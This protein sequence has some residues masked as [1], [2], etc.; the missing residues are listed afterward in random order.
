MHLIEV[1]RIECRTNMLQCNHKLDDDTLPEAAL[2]TKNDSRYIPLRFCRHY[3]NPLH[4]KKFGS[5]EYAERLPMPHMIAVP[6]S[7]SDSD[8]DSD[9][10]SRDSYRPRNSSYDSF[11]PVEP[12]YYKQPRGEAHTSTSRDNYSRK[13]AASN[14]SSDSDHASSRDDPRSH[15]ASWNRNVWDSSKQGVSVSD[16][17]KRQPPRDR[18][19]AEFI[20]LENSGLWDRY[21]PPLAR[22]NLDSWSPAPPKTARMERSRSR[23]PSREYSLRDRD[24]DYDKADRHIIRTGDSSTKYIQL[25]KHD[26]NKIHSIKYKKGEKETLTQ[27]DIKKWVENCEDCI[28]AHRLPDFTNHIDKEMSRMFCLEVCSRTDRFGEPILSAKAKK[29]LRRDKN[30]IDSLVDF[31]SASDVARFRDIM[32]LAWKI[33]QPKDFY[34]NDGYKTAIDAFY[35]TKLHIDAIDETIHQRWIMEINRQIEIHELDN[36]SFSNRNKFT[37]EQWRDMWEAFIQSIERE[38]D[39]KDKNDKNP[40][41]YCKPE[42]RKITE[43]LKSFRRVDFPQAV[44]DITGMI[45]AYQDNI[46]KLSTR[47]CLDVKSLAP[48][49][50][51]EKPSE[52]SHSK[53]KKDKYKKN[54]NSKYSTKNENSK[55]SSSSKSARESV[56]M[57]IVESLVICYMASCRLH[58]VYTLY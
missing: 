21:E 3:S 36:F 13:R 4:Y 41:G 2:P 45:R 37:P 35:K 46:A 1:M 50:L 22:G 27:D 44:E 52:D 33:E 42:L 10:N 25:V 8:S 23:S 29:R 6:E 40:R 57:F 30:R 47:L 5:Y 24:L 14:E 53:F 39:D 32:K 7:D 12:S 18:Q 43:H 20:H 38:K 16:G 15:G 19:T 31:R 34:T 17:R 11:R 48:L 55:H 56:G 54:E 51:S 49:E 58:I 26:A 28:I 9:S